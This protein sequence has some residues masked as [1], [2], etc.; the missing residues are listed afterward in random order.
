[1]T[2]DCTGHGVPG[3]FMSMLSINLLNQIIVEKGYTKTD[4]IFNKLREMIINSLKTDDY[5]TKDGLD[6]S[7]CK[8]DFD[9][10]SLDYSAANNPIY[11]VRDKQLTVLPFQ[12]NPIGYSEI[13]EPFVTNHIQLQKGDCLYTIT[14]GFADQFGGIK[15]KKFKYQQ[16]KDSLLMVNALPMIEQQIKLS[17][18]F[19]SWRGELEQVDDVCIIGIRV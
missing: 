9:S 3:A 6:A 7:L 2:A 19:E 13:S 12:K 17:E 5:Y 4:D 16:L 14:D 18:I 15:G 8:I 11:L 1:V 10:L